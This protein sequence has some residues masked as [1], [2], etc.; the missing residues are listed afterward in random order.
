MN[1]FLYT[2]ING[3][4]KVPVNT[5]L[6]SSISLVHIDWFSNYIDLIYQTMY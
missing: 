2:S 1:I 4:F 3:L 6:V 5:T